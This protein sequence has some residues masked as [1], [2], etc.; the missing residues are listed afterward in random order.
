MTAVRR[1]GRSAGEEEEED[2]NCWRMERMEE[3]I[4]K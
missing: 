3:A 2:V 1:G 4:A